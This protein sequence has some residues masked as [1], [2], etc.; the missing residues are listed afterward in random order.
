MREMRRKWILLFC[1]AMVWLSACG[2][3]EPQTAKRTLIVATDATLPPMSFLN[4][5][6][7]LAGFEIDLIDAVAKQAGFEYDLI[8]VEWNGLFG[9]LITKKYDLVISS[10]TILEERRERMAFSVP[11]LQSGLSLVV[12]RGTQGVT[13]LEDVQAQDGIVGAQRATTAFFYLEDY[14][15]LNKQAYE[16]YGHAIQD[17][18]K[19]EIAAVLGESTGTLYYKNN[20]A[21]VFR[22]IK[23][24]GDILT[25]EHYG[26]VARKDEAELLQRVN[27]ALNKL[28][29]DGTVARLHEKWELGQAAVVPK[30]IASGKED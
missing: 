22:E 10:V 20:D 6:N 29:A 15:E 7:Q 16:L 21:A 19:G 23:M 13:S 12:Q 18:I 30:T 17:L 25:E 4:D 24:V 26:I 14:S 2:G 5:Q 9:G 3:E 11:Y 28:L 8:N 1:T 27:E